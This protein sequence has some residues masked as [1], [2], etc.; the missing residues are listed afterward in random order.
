MPTGDHLQVHFSSCAPSCPSRRAACEH[1]L[2][3][4]AKIGHATEPL[5][6]NN[7]FRQQT[8]AEGVLRQSIFCAS[9][10]THVPP[11]F[12]SRKKISQCI[13]IFHLTCATTKIPTFIEL[14]QRKESRIQRPKIGRCQLFTA[15]PRA[16]G[17]FCRRWLDNLSAPV[18]LHFFC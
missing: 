8:T 12:W 7:V 14:V 15:V 10:E 18:T 4:E 3:S 5:T 6:V 1:V 9:S 13:L 2:S 16:L 17:D 11:E